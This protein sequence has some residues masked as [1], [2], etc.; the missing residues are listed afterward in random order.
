M[1][2]LLGHSKLSTT[3]KYMHELEG[4]QREAM[5]KI[6]N[7]IWFPKKQADKERNHNSTL[8]VA[9]CGPVATVASK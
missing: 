7:L 5:G 9:Q 3:Q 8:F 4:Q 6:E 2:Q 1:K